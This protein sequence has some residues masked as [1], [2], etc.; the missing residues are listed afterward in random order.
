MFD[1]SGGIVALAQ[2]ELPQIFPQPGLGRARPRGDLGDA[3]RSGRGGAREGRNRPGAIIAAIGITN[4][5]ETTIVWDRETGEPVHNAIVWQDRRTAELCERL[6]ADGLEE[7]IRGRTGL[8]IDAYFSAHQA[9]AGFSTTSPARAL[10]PRR[11]ARVRHGRLAGW[12]GSSRSGGVHVTDVTNA[13]RTMLFNI[14]TLAWDEDLLELLARAASM[15]PEVRSSSEVYARARVGFLRG[16]LDRGD[17]RRPAGGALRP[18]VPRARHAEE[19]LRHRLLPAAEHRRGAGRLAQPPA[20]DRRVAAS[21]A[22][23]TT[24]SRAASSSAARSCSGCATGSASSASRRRDRGAGRQ[25]ARQRRRLPRA[26]VRRPRR[27]ALGSV[28][29]RHDRRPHARHDGGAHRA[30]GAR[31][32]RVP[33]RRPARS[34]AAT[35][36]AFALHELR[37]DGGAAANDRCC[38]SRPTCS[39]CRSCGPKVTETTALG[40]AYL[41]GLAVGFWESPGGDRGPLAGADSASSRACAR[42]EAERRIARW[43]RGGRAREALGPSRGIRVN[44]DAMLARARRFGIGSGFGYGGVGFLGPRRHRRRRD[45]RRA[46]RSTRPRAA[47][48]R[49]CS[50]STTSARARRAAAPSSCTAACAIS[51]RATSRS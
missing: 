3:D 29:A 33:G 47:T 4:Q 30:R 50:S 22:G 28:R 19:H 36:R 41:A 35:T 21:A 7:S 40:A 13:S 43:W 45:G 49:S 27:A 42:P 34:D 32:H 12:S 10:G 37:V 23:P 20:D 17:R 8:L 26:R 48:G 15:L 51:S 5:R 14:H 6:R 24:R 1:P 11:E 46:S 25:R 39:A 16:G 9:R 18:D 38:S 2:R 31:V 44:R